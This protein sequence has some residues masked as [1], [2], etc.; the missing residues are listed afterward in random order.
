[1]EKRKEEK[2]KL[3]GRGNSSTCAC[4]RFSLYF[5]SQS[6][7]THTH[8]Q[9]RAA[10]IWVTTLSL[11]PIL[12]AGRQMQ[13]HSQRLELRN[14]WVF[15]KTKVVLECWRYSLPYICGRISWDWVNLCL[16]CEYSILSCCP[17]FT[18]C[19]CKPV[20]AMRSSL[21]CFMDNSEI[22]R[23]QHQSC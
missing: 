17:W 22:G 18:F 7:N 9:W 21:L 1:M 16:W 20:F 13:I 11:L 4:W 2:N 6:M 23:S 5:G 15:W 3:T 10:L 12:P 14:E 8:T 19:E